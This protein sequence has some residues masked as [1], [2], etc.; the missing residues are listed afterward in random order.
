MIK[1]FLL[2]I[3]SFLLVNCSLNENSKIWNNKN[4]KLDEIKNIKL[5]LEKKNG[6]P[7]VMS[8]L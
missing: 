6:V 2:I 3:F 8:I 4:K 5:I 7:K 1:V